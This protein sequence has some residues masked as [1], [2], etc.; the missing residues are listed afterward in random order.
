MPRSLIIERLGNTNVLELVPTTKF[1]FAAGEL[2]IDWVPVDETLAATTTDAI[3]MI[4][5]GVGSAI[6]TGIAG[7][8]RVPYAC[9][10]TGWTLLADQAGDIEI[11]VW[12][13]TLANYPP[14]ALTQLNLFGTALAMTAADHAEDTTLTGWTTSIAAGT[15][16]RFNVDTTSGTITRLNVT[17]TVSRSTS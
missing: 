7:D 8:V 2:L 14:T 16:L 12:A 3:T 11:G 17:F 5:N 15:V 9:T 10:I 6:A 13:D 4:I 1:N